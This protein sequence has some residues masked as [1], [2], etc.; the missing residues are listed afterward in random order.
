M[1]SKPDYRASQEQAKCDW[2][3]KTPRYWK[4]YRGRNP[5][6]TERNRK[7]QRDRNRKRRSQNAKTEALKTT[8]NRATTQET[9]HLIAKMDATKVGNHEVLIESWTVPLIAKMDAIKVNISMISMDS[10]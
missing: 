9:S 5:E 1:K 6:K 7:L 2:N 10:E 4:N 3:S 8:V